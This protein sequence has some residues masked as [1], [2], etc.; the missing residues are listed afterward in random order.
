[1]VGKLNKTHAN[2]SLKVKLKL[3]LEM[4]LL[5]GNN[6][7]QHTTMTLFMSLFTCLFDFFCMI[8][9]LYNFHLTFIKNDSKSNPP[10]FLPRM[11]GP[12]WNPGTFSPKRALQKHIATVSVGVM[13]GAGW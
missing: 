10:F 4:N 7:E 12:P 5:N 3:Q 13:F 2:S 6:A 8:V 9:L 1:M 11:N